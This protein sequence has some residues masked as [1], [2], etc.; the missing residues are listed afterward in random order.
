MA[1]TKILSHHSPCANCLEENSETRHYDPVNCK[2]MHHFCL[3]CIKRVEFECKTIC[4]LCRE[5]PFKVVE[6][7]SQKKSIEIYLKQIYRPCRVLS[8]NLGDSVYTLKKLIEEITQI[9][10]EQI[11][12]F[13]QSKNLEVG[14]EEDDKMLLLQ[15]FNIQ[16]GSTVFLILGMVSSS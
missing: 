8:V 7:D 12:L 2:N 10:Y 13:F 15:D 5:T 4:P 6:E 9:P 14:I 11:R 16:E 3:P 1:L